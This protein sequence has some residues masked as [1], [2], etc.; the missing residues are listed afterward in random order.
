MLFIPEKI[1]VGFQNRKNTYTGKLAYVIYFDKKNKIHKE[2][3]FETWRD[4]SI[5]VIDY[6]NEPT[7]GFVLNKK[8]GGYKSDWNFRQ[9]YVRVFDPRGFEFEITV[10][11]L[12][13]IL[14][15][16]DC[17]KGKGL[18]GQFV[19]SWDR[20][21][22]VLLPVSTESYKESATYTQKIGKK[23]KIK[24]LEV[25]C[26]Y[27]DSRHEK[28]VYIGKL[29]WYSPRYSNTSQNKFIFVNK[30]GSFSGEEKLNLLYKTDDPKIENMAE[31]LEKFYKS[32]NGS[33]V[34]SYKIVEE[35][36]GKYFIDRDD[37]IEHYS[38]YSEQ[39]SNYMNTTKDNF[40]TSYINNR[41]IYCLSEE[42][43]AE[44]DKMYNYNTYGYR[45]LTYKS[46][47]IVLDKA[48]IEGKL[49]L[50]LESGTEI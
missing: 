16:C 22:L 13:F 40:V 24:E 11:N 15:E 37:K 36:S 34:V 4:K 38:K 45:T 28:Q 39:F 31:I 5:D 29:D 12:M 6:N 47:I 26:T 23:V 18:E 21:D 42:R 17:S 27:I 20:G 35:K 8:V 32:E 48:P 50:I 33:A 10:E 19:Y 14:G 46:S 3:S 25:G 41:N 1:R 7:E 2:R 30:N 9:S 44:L 49:V 43:K